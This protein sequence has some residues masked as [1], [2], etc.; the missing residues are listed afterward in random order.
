[1]SS[2]T[3]VI[4]GAGFSHNAGLPL[5]KN[6]FNSE[7]FVPSQGAKERFDAVFRDWYNWKSIHNDRGPEQFLTELYNGIAPALIP[8]AWA[9]ELIAAVLASPL[10]QDRGPY[11][12]RYAGR[13]TRPGNVPIHDMFWDV[14][15][16]QFDVKAVLTTNYDILI[17]RGLRH[18]PMIR[19][20]RPGIYYGGLPRPQILKGNS[21]PFS[22]SKSERFIELE[23]KIPLYKLHGSLNWSL[24]EGIL[25][26]YQDL[27][28]AF[29]RGGDA[30]IVP[31]IVEK[32]APTWLLGVWEEAQQALSS[33]TTWLV[34]GY[35]LPI[36]DKAVTQ[37]VASAGSGAAVT[38]IVLL[39]PNSKDLVPRW[40]AVAPKAELYPLPGLPRGIRPLLEAVSKFR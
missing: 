9:V 16:S 7:F 22:V 3:A 4:L 2:P 36:Y 27:R 28:P 40:Q 10:P 24:K 25:S 12:M 20:N 11:G 30:Q 35:S 5:A 15:L 19:T 34:C 21:S 6:L 33:C 37:L 26:L 8:W 23:G 17:E 31:P 1:M 29:R 14:V 39:D 38:K 13:I 32:E 18:R